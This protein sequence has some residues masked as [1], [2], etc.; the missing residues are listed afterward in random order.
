MAKIYFNQYS[1]E[2]F[3][4]KKQVDAAGKEYATLSDMA[5]KLNQKDF[6]EKRIKQQL[7]YV[8]PGEQV[9]YFVKKGYK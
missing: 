8:L 9:Y 4:L 1:N 2:Y 5:I 6:L 7:G 3:Y